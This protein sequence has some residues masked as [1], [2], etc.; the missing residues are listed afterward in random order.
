MVFGP[1][2][3]IHRSP[4]LPHEAAKTFARQMRRL[5]ALCCLVLGGCSS[6]IYDLPADVAPDSAAAIEGARKG[7]SE[8]RLIEPVEVSAV[9][10]SHP[11]GPG[12]Y[13]LC[14]RGNSQAVSGQRVYAVFLKGNDYVTVRMAIMADDCELQGFSPLDLRPP[15]ASMAV[16]GER[17]PAP[18]KNQK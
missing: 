12:P 17:S 5:T 9:Q 13:R 14:I 8:A 7:A 3:A 4:E 6:A 18:G 10:P 1:V 15:K 16:T 2:M 11:L